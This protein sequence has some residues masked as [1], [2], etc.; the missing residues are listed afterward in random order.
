MR[1]PRFHLSTAIVL[2]FVCGVLMALNLRPGIRPGRYEERVRIGGLV[3][4]N[5][6]R[7]WN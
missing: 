4:E 3:P 7:K 2:M 1:L 5:T 6:I